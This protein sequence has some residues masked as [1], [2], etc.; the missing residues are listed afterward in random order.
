MGGKGPD[1]ERGRLTPRRLSPCL[2]KGLSEDL[3]TEDDDLRNHTWCR[4]QAKP[5]R[6]KK[7]RGVSSNSRGI[8]RA[9]ASQVGRCKAQ[10]PSSTSL[11]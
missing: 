8:R 3:R 2:D 5:S 1:E 6:K 11:V 9:G 10:S 7:R 4:L